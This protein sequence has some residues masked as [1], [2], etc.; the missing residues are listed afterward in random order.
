[1]A[2]TN[3]DRV[4]RGL[5]LLLEGLTPFVERQFQAI[6]GDTW[7]SIAATTLREAKDWHADNGHLDVQ[8][9][10]ILMW[11]NWNNVFRQILGHAE[12]NL[13]SEL[14]TVRNRDAH[15]ESFSTDDAYRA[16]DSIQRL[17]QAVSAPEAAE[18]DRAKADLLRLKF[19][20]QTRNVVRRT[21]SAPT[22]GRPQAGLPCWRELITPHPDVAAGRFEHAEFAADLNQVYRGEG[23]PEY[24]DPHEFYARTFITEGMRMLLVDALRR[25]GG[26]GGDPVVELQTNFG[27]GKTH[28]MLALYHL[29]SGTPA[30]ELSGIEPILKTTDR[31][32]VV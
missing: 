18:V 21:A 16:L 1:M 7:R 27:G 30:G 6:Y 19:E 23:E 11:D 12:R 31:K 32:S 22:E 8:A 2:Q 3:R 15:Q 25:L 29:F 14:R 20:E 10:L 26:S 13:V 5:D 24:R 9:L 4:H 17:L 28:S